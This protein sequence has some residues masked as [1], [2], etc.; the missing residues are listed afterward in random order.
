[1]LPYKEKKSEL[2]PK[3]FPYQRRVY[4]HLRICDRE[5]QVN[6]RR[7]NIDSI[8]F[9][10]S[11]ILMLLQF[12][13]LHI[14]SFLLQELPVAPTFFFPKVLIFKI[15]MFQECGFCFLSYHLSFFYLSFSFVFFITFFH[16]GIFRWNNAHTKV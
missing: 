2:Q 5:T 11:F 6:Q 10:L 14:L 7:F 1:M 16:L 3:L 12:L 8:L 13:L 4:V 9:F 15:Q